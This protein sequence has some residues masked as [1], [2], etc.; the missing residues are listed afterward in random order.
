MKFPICVACGSAS[1]LQH[2]HLVP[3]SRGGSDHETNL[4]TLCTRCHGKLHDFEI[5]VDH[6]KLVSGAIEKARTSGKRLGPKAPS[7]EAF[8]DSLGARTPVQEVLI[9]LYTVDGLNLVEIAELSWQDLLVRELSTEFRSVQISQE[10]LNAVQ[11]A[12]AFLKLT[13]RD[14]TKKVSATPHS[15]NGRDV[16]AIRVEIHRLKNTEAKKQG[17][18]RPNKH[19][20]VQMIVVGDQRRFLNP[21]TSLKSRR[22]LDAIPL[23]NGKVAYIPGKLI[24][25][26]GFEEAKRRRIAELT[27]QG[28]L[29]A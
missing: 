15:P 23:L 22:F 20:G 17:V 11:D 28:L 1:D 21:E 4:I 25:E 7:Y 10:T 9:R 24:A 16:G 12:I 6:A 5:A 29:P 26:V 19:K 14:L 13:G 27:E 8:S 2:H 18:S 3:K